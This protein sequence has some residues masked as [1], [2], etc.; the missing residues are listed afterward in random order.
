MDYYDHSD[1]SL[2]RGL[3]KSR[4]L[5]AR[6]PDWIATIVG[7]QTTLATLPLGESR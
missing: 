3:S 2:L 7:H 1:R 4:Q 5:G 6:D